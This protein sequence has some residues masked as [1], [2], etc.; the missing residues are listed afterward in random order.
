MTEHNA[1]AFNAYEL[2]ENSAGEIMVL[3]FT[4]GDAPLNPTFFINKDEHSIEL[5]RNKSDIVILEGLQ[6]ESIKK[7]ENLKE[8]YICELKHNENP[9][10][11]HEI[12]H[13]YAAMAKK[14]SAQNTRKSAASRK[15]AHPGNIERKSPQ[16][17]RKCSKQSQTS[18]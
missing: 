12:L 16:S 2:V 18:K 3:L 14:K 9:E 5:I 6:P 7:L 10:A 4:E 11:E 15:T 1:L 13:A 8:L 17:K